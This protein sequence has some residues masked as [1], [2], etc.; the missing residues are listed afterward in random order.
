MADLEWPCLSGAERNRYKELARQDRV[1][2]TVIRYEPPAPAAESRQD[3]PDVP[4]YVNVLSKF[5][6][7]VDA[8]SETTVAASANIRNTNSRCFHARAVVGIGSDIKVSDSIR[9]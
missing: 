3:N 5:F 9:R 7:I 2:L 1:P 6:V 4:D 8:P